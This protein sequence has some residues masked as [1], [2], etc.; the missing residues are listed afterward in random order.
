MYH[1]GEFRWFCP[2]TPPDELAGWIGAGELGVAEAPR[3]D[4]YLVLPGCETTGVKIREGRF[5]IKAR[6]SDPQAVVVT[7]SVSGI[8]DRWVKWSRQAPNI[9]A[10]RAL[11][12]A[13]GDDWAFV[14]K[15]RRLRKFTLVDGTVREVA[16][17]ELPLRGFQVELSALRATGGKLDESE[18]AT[19]RLPDADPWWSLSLEAFG[20]PGNVLQDVLAAADYLCRAVP[21]LRLGTRFSA[22]YPAWLAQRFA[23]DTLQDDD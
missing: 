23:T 17:S 6:T 1:S 3:V 9:D 7:D 19:S 11:V 4:A 14:G 12:A 16:A 20:P 5:E 22:G 18:A 2:G 13:P 21:G 10:L 15:R 8:R